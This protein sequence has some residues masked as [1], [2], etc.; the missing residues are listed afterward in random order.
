MGRYKLTFPQ[1]TDPASQAASQAL[2]QRQ[3]QMSQYAAARFQEWQAN[4]DERNAIMQARIQKAKSEAELAG[5]QF[6]Y[7]L[8]KDNE[9]RRQT[10]AY[11]TA[12]PALQESLKQNGIYPGSPRYAAEI[13]AFAAELPDAVTHNDAI[14]KELAGFAKVDEN[15]A[16]ISKM[17]AERNMTM[18]QAQMAAQTADLASQ[19]MRPTSFS[20]SSKGI[21]VKASRP[22]DDMQKTLGLTPDQFLN[23]VNAKQGKFDDAGN[24]T[25]SLAPGEQANAIQFQAGEQKTDPSKLVTHSLPLNQFNQYRSGLGLEP[26]PAFAAP[27]GSPTPAPNLN[28]LAQRALNDPN[29]TDEHRARARQILGIQE[30]NAQ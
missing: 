19:N 2:A 13:S 22:I 25:Q 5:A 3:A 14:R 1:R 29:A 24:F 12:M 23:H 10:T 15:A 26:L 6:N 8:W 30:D 17:M 20:S 11:Y 27:G 7:N 28:D 9:L 21:D 16:R 18:Q 4:A